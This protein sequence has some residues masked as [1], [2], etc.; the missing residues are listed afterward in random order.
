MAGLFTLDEANAIGSYRR[1]EAPF[2][3]SPLYDVKESVDL[4]ADEAARGLQRPDF[5]RRTGMGSPTC[6]RARGDVVGDEKLW[7]Q[8]RAGA[9][10]MNV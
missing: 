10:T 5:L 4:G 6:K 9:S 8:S 7:R 1:D 3:K 2:R